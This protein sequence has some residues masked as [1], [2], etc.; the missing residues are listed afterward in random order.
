MNP[1]DVDTWYV[2]VD[3]TKAHPADVSIDESGVLKHANGVAV[4]LRESGLPL[5]TGDDNR[6]NAM[7]AD[8]GKEAEEKAAKKP[9]KVAKTKPGDSPAETDREIKAGGDAKTYETR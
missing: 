1:P 2:L 7:A 6:E 5:T 8:L 3:G 9:G 4:A